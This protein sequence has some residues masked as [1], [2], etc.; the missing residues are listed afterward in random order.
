MF[1]H[2][3][4]MTPN[5]QTYKFRLSQKCKLTSQPCT[6]PLQQDSFVLINFAGSIPFLH[7]FLFQNLVI[8][9][10]LKAILIP[11]IYFVSNFQVQLSYMYAICLS[12]KDSID[13]KKVEV[14]FMLLCIKVCFTKECS[15]RKYI[16]FTINFS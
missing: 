15:T 14:T 8:L 1:T 10:F 9:C 11:V 7:S 13:T 12:Q 5:A 6:I 3:S 4:M 16:K 2:I